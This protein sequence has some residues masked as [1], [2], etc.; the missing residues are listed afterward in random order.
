MISVVI[1]AYNAEKTLARCLASL[2][3]QTMREY[4]IVIVNDGSRDGTARVAEQWKATLAQAGIPLTVIYQDNAG[5]NAARNRG[6]RQ[7][8]G[9]YIIFFDADI[10]AAPAMLERMMN[11]LKTH[12]EAS[13]AYSAFKFG[14]KTFELWPFDAVRLRHM[15]YIHT[16][17]L[18]RRADFPGFDE[19]L[20]RFQDWDIWLTMLE[21]R[22]TGIC[23]PDILFRIVNTGGTMS[24]WIP[25]F[26]YKLPWPLFGY[27]P[28]TVSRYR[29]AREIIKTKHHL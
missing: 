1:P 14:W 23:I 12:P 26:F 11:A 28:K 21:R 2:R 10:V 6:A 20:N 22:K 29:E 19:H 13:Y 27:T 7:A 4:E 8:R 5:A 25:S 17:S 15:P 3:H 24:T 9:E 16:T 18:I